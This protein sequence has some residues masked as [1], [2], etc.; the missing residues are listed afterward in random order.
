MA[1]QSELK[2]EKVILN[3]EELKE[4]THDLLEGV[5]DLEGLRTTSKKVL[6]VT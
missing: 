3:C 4:P 1:E 6:D 5:K 2:G